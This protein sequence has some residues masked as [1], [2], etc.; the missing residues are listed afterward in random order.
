MIRFWDSK[1]SGAPPLLSWV[2]RRPAEGFRVGK[3]S[4]NTNVTL[5]R[6]VPDAVAFLIARM[7]PTAR[8]ALLRFTD[9]IDLQLEIAKGFDTGMSVRAMLGLWGENPELLAALPPIAR[10]PDSASSCL[11]VECWRRLRVQAADAELVAADVTID[12]KL[13]LRD[14]GTVF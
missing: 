13:R 8:K 11:L 3:G 12:V 10:H 6:T 2:V 5:P 1:L 9:E 7:S 4:K 14:D